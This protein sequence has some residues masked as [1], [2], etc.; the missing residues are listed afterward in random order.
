MQA[1]DVKSLVRFEVERLFRENKIEIPF[2]QRDVWVRKG[3]IDA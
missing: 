2:P 1:E 3:N